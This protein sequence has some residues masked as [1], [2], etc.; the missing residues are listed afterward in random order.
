M[1][2]KLLDYVDFE[3]ANALLEGFNKSTGFVTAILDLDGNI[4]SQSGWRN[5]CTDFHRVHPV[6]ARNCVVSD[7]VLSSDMRAQNKYH[8]Y[9]CMNGLIDVRVPIVVRGEYIANLFSGQFFFEKPDLNFFTQ[10]AKKYNYDEKAYLEALQMVPIVSQDKVEIILDF[11]VNIMQLIIEMTAEKLDQIE[12]YHSISESEIALKESQKYL[13][14][15]VNDLLESQ[16]IAH[17]GTWR[18]D[19]E[20]NDVVW[21]E[22]LYNMYGFDSS[23]P[24]PP[25][26]EHMKLFT[27]ES[28]ELLSKSLEN[29]RTKG[30]PYELELET[31]TKSGSNGWMWVRGEA[32]FDENGKII[33]LHGAAQDITERKKAEAHLSYLSYHDHL[34]GLFNR[35]YFEEQ[36]Q[37]LDDAKNYPLSVIMC[38][39]NGLKLVN[40]SFGHKAGDELLIKAAETIRKA[41]RHRDVI[42]RVGGD[43]F[44]VILCNTDR[45]EALHIS[46]LIKEFASKEMIENIELSISYGYDTK[47]SVDQSMI[48]IMANAE[49]YMYRH[50]LYERSSLRSK[51]IDLIMSALFEKS[52]REAIHSKRVG[53][54]CMAIGTKMN[55]EANCKMKSSTEAK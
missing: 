48:E 37:R 43:E 39:V 26:T 35:R 4:L 55:L 5:I 9:K 27:S 47:I 10:Q 18:L 20:T 13:R 3:K 12:L 16:K 32:Q 36:L 51:N 53:K 52:N 14:Q 44:V 46:N 11:L 22:E 34:T 40:D 17:L 7:I 30:I 15:N 31:I 8:F 50:K 49:N 24:P 19:L 42:S 45:E 38:D 29:T 21:S 33:S 25:Y 23:V 28:W 2:K 6:T 41:C 1:K 54:I